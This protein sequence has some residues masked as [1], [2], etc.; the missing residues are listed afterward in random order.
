MF[1]QYLQA[2]AVKNFLHQILTGSTTVLYPDPCTVV[3]NCAESNVGAENRPRDLPATL[4]YENLLVVSVPHFSNLFK[5]HFC[6]SFF[7]Y[8]L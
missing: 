3:H 6:M 4:F 7:Y 8:L 5:R 2:F 1:V